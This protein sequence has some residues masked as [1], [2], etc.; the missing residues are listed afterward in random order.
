MTINNL[1]KLFNK[2]TIND[3]IDPFFNADIDSYFSDDYQFSLNIKRSQ[4]VSLY[5]N[6]HV[7]IRQQF[8]NHL[9]LNKRL[10]LFK[11]KIK[12][13]KIDEWLMSKLKIDFFTG[14]LLFFL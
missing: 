8:F 5:C 2:F 11:R 3:R 14:Y 13:A 1:I 10:S 4:K 12:A 9:D 7:D 6:D